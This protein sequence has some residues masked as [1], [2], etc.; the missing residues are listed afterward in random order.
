MKI[1]VFLHSGSLSRCCEVLVCSNA[2]MIKNEISVFKVSLLKDENYTLSKVY[3]DVY[4]QMILMWISPLKATIIA[5][6][7]TNKTKNE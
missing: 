6:E 7:S 3:G 1:S 5:A 2:G 4:M